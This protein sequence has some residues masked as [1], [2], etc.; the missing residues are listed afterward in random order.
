[1]HFLNR[2]NT[3]G[4][5]KEDFIFVVVLCLSS[6]NAQGQE[7]GCPYVPENAQSV[8]Q[9]CS[10]AKICVST[11]ESCK[12]KRVCACD[13]FCGLRCLK[14]RRENYCRELQTPE[15]VIVEYDSL[16]IRAFNTTVTY[17]CNS[18]SV[19]LSGDLTRKCRGDG[20]WSGQEPHCVNINDLPRCP[21]LTIPTNLMV[22]GG[23][24]NI[25]K[26]FRLFV[27]PPGFETVDG[28]THVISRCE[29]DGSWSRQPPIC[30]AIINGHNE[31][32][33]TVNPCHE[34]SCEVWE[35]CIGVDGEPTCSC[36][37]PSECERIAKS[38]VC[39]T[40]GRNYTNLCQLK[41]M[42][43]FFGRD[44]ELEKETPC[45]SEAKTEAGD[46]SIASINSDASD[47]DGSI[48]DDY[49]LRLDLLP[50]LPDASDEALEQISDRPE[51]PPILPDVP[52]HSGLGPIYHVPGCHPDCADECQEY[53]I[54]PSARKLAGSGLHI[55]A[56]RILQCNKGFGFDGEAY[57]SSLTVTCMDNG[58][59]SPEV[60]S[61]IGTIQPTVPIQTNP[62]D[63]IQCE[64]WETCAVVSNEAQC[65]CVKPSE[66]PAAESQDDMICGSD[67]QEYESYC[68][69]LATACF[70]D[71]SIFM[72]NNGACL[73]EYDFG[74]QDGD[75]SLLSS[76]DE[77]TTQAK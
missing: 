14:V 10:I 32:E 17:T 43:C 24:R 1:M 48:D 50:I 53:D 30:S 73:E 57:G 25:Y 45:S 8:G 55:G 41:S 22:M 70:F 15:N 63:S 36:K 3:N 4:R 13:G 19:L 64:L 20:E 71:R 9:D 40:D 69:L 54:P 67:N 76:V 16:R 5:S 7:T 12:G 46:Y 61:C 34:G 58:Q 77:T 60:P 2:R 65:Y 47:G 62:C 44:V 49:S 23:N 6:L 38:V 42:A 11:R 39:G 56:V 66:C 18:E 51:L 59:W 26:S 33:P 75:Y 52:D 21:T 72:V 27:C 74:I 37:H 28:E 29:M 31:I 68:H 35:T